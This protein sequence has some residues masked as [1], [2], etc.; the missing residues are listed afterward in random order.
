MKG[1]NRTRLTITKTVTTENINSARRE[2]KATNTER[3]VTTRRAINI[4]D[5]KMFTTRKNTENIA[6]STMTVP[7][8]STMASTIICIS[9]S[10]CL[11]ELTRKEQAKRY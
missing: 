11:R 5:S 10:R 4:R 3:Q 9:I 7:L 6:N 1:E 8:R 2:A